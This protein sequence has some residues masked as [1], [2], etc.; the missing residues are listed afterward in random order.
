MYLDSSIF[1]SAHCSRTSAS[2]ALKV[3]ER[4]LLR[5]VRCCREEHWSTQRGAT[6]KCREK[7][8]GRLPGGIA[9]GQPCLSSTTALHSDLCLLCV[10]Q[11][12]FQTKVWLMLHALPRVP[13]RSRSLM[14]LRIRPFNKHPLAH[15]TLGLFILGFGCY[16][17]SVSAPGTSNLNP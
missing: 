11:T 4:G 10:A 17:S 9:A 8:R 7:T 16:R 12:L 1:C 15:K 3:T 14:S 13:G 6:M 5:E 2:E